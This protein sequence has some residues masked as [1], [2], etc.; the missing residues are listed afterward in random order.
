MLS[1]FWRACRHCSIRPSLHT[2]ATSHHKFSGAPFSSSARSALRATPPS[3]ARYIRFGESDTFDSKPA[4]GGKRTD[5]WYRVGIGAVAAGAVWY[6]AHL[7]RVPETGRWRYISIDPKM[8]TKLAEQMHAQILRENKGKILPAN[9]PLTRVVKEISEQLLNAN[10]LGHLSDERERRAWSLPEWL[11]GQPDGEQWSYDANISSEREGLAPGTG[12]REW[13]VVVVHDP[14]VINAA[15]TYGN[16]IVWTGLFQ[17]C[18]TRNEL[19]SV[20]SHEM[21]HVVARHVSERVSLTKYL[22]AIAIGIAAATGIGFPL[23]D[24]LTNLVLGLPMSR[25][26]ELE[27]DKIGLKL[28][29]KACYDPAGAVSMF[30]KF[31]MHSQSQ[32]GIPDFLQ[33]HPSHVKRIE[34]SDMTPTIAHKRPMRGLIA[35]APL[36]DCCTV[37]NEEAAARSVCRASR[38][39]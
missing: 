26:H 12:G 28:A 32:P 36:T 7:E 39:S 35:P 38:Y 16:I 18:Q 17:L 23:A 10:N 14:R 5:L 1:A 20:L 37:A 6:V 34:V 29:A 3:R 30:Q 13:K 4:G 11:T 8:E 2:A 25:S 27:A 33:T 24:M 21:G 31:E 15:A 19:A 22:L 9:H